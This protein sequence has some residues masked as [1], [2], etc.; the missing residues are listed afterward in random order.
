MPTVGRIGIVGAV[1]GIGFRGPGRAGISRFG[2]APRPRGIFI[3]C[4]STC[5]FHN[6]RGII[7]IGGI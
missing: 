2:L 7:G 3:I 5:I 6:A 4:A 1:P